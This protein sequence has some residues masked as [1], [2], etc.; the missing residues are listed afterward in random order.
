MTT[1]QRPAESEEERLD[2][3]LAE[4][5]GELRVAL[6]GVQVLFAFLLTVPFSSGFAGSTRFE[7]DVYLV[8]LLATA[9]STALL[10]APSAYHRI[11][12]RQR[13]RAYIIA[14]ANRLMIAG[15]GFLTVAMTGAVLLVSHHLFAGGVAAAVSA[16]TFLA[17][18]LLWYVGPLRRRAK[19]R[20]EL[21]E[22][23][24]T[25]P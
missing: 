5:L 13:D 17:L 14:L 25:G 2:R 3:N 12:F 9:T 8:T 21:R 20:A 10:L 1:E 24:V 18:A 7:H 15:L 6:P 16:G 19:R 4:L 11:E 23:V 22:D